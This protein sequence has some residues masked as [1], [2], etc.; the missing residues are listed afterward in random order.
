M[1]TYSVM[2]RFTGY[3]EMEIEADSREEAIEEAWANA[4]PEGVDSWDVDIDDV[5]YLGEEDEEDE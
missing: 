2:V 1:A 5:E 3:M 4:E